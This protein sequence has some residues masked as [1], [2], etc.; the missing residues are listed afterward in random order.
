MGERSGLGSARCVQARPSLSANNCRFFVQTGS[1]PA[2]RRFVTSTSE[3]ERGLAKQPG[4]TPRATIC[5]QS[6]TGA[7][8]WTCC[9]AAII[10][11]VGLFIFGVPRGF[12]DDTADKLAPTAESRR[13]RKAADRGLAFLVDDAVKWRK[14]RQCATCHHGT[15][16]VWALSE[17]KSQGYTID[18]NSL[19]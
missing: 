17:A 15:M 4:R 16:T 14:E 3:F 10:T 6:L 9:G 12:A 2:E 13:V 5:P 1:A 8:R 7:P 11:L 18:T 19:A